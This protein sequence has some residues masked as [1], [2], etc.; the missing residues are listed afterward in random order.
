M[1]C[2]DST[3]LCFVKRFKRFKKVKDVDLYS[4][5]YAPGTLNAHLRTLDKCT[6]GHVPP[7]RTSAPGRVHPWFRDHP[8]QSPPPPY[9]HDLRISVSL[10]LW[11]DYWYWLHWWRGVKKNSVTLAFT[12]LYSLLIIFWLYIM[13]RTSLLDWKYITVICGCMSRRWHIFNWPSVVHMNEAEHSA[14]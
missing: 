4:A 9:Q 8:G 6:P 5:S 3:L 13:S 1:Y 10:C 11:I 2:M 7:P 12:A 14:L